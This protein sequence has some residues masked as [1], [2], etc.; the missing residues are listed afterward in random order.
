M[1]LST[2]AEFFIMFLT[3]SKKYEICLQDNLGHGF[4]ICWITLHLLKFQ[5]AAIRK[6]TPLMYLS[7]PAEFFI[8]F[9]TTFQKKYEICL[10]DNLGFFLYVGLGFFLFV[11]LHVTSRVYLVY[12]SILPVH[13]L[14]FVMSIY[15]YF[16]I[17]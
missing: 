1:Y 14:M 11:G 8:I 6:K 10:Q 5:S 17:L 16:F 2:P 7:T 12:F 15:C 13:S 4:F 3:T 9:L